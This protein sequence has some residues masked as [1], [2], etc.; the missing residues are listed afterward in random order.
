LTGE[1]EL[2]GRLVSSGPTGKRD[3]TEIRES[4]AK[5]LHLNGATIREAHGHA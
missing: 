1:Q 4:I 3:V 2:I 5:V